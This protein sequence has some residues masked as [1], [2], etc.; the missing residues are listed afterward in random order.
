MDEEISIHK[1]NTYGGH[2]VIDKLTEV[3]REATKF[4]FETLPNS[5][6]CEEGFNQAQEDLI[7]K[8]VNYDLHQFYSTRLAEKKSF[9]KVVPFENYMK[10]IPNDSI[11]SPL[12]KMPEDLDH[13]AVEL[14]DLL[15]YYMQD[16]KSS[17]SPIEFVKK[18]LK[19]CMNSPEDIKD[20]AYVQVLKQMKENFSK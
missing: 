3:D 1:V 18:H 8:I 7:S 19:L 20:E 2:A 13:V 16:K 4:D 10:Y 11:S 9:F 14:Y 12:L 17:K 15:K 5:T 6:D